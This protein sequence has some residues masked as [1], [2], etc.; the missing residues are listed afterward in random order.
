MRAASF[1]LRWGA[2]RH[3]FDDFSAG[4]NLGR[5]SPRNRTITSMR[6]MTLAAVFGSLSQPCPVLVPEGSTQVLHC[7]FTASGVESAVTRRQ[8]SSDGPAARTGVLME[9]V[10][11]L[12]AGVGLGLARSERIPKGGPRAFTLEGWPV[13][14]WRPAHG[15]GMEANEPS[16][17]GTQGDQQLGRALPC[18]RAASSPMRASDRTV[19]GND[20]AAKSASEGASEF[21]RSSASDRSSN[22]GRS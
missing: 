11:V 1:P 13:Q 6:P 22:Q 7:G 20:L 18:K 12:G 3:A 15:T 8:G 17:R 21:R 4:I 5:P 9:P 10:S 2:S 14:R 19:S 16:R